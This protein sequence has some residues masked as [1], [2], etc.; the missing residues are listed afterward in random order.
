MAYFYDFT[1][2]RICYILKNVDNHSK[3][4]QFFTVLS[5]LTK[6]A[7]DCLAGNLSYTNNIIKFPRL[8]HMAGTVIIIV[9]FFYHFKR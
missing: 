9:Y 2:H 1:N 7:L 8:C 6:F 4:W 3:N 5:T